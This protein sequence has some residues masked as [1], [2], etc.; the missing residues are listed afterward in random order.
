MPRRAVTRWLLGVLL[1]P[2]LTGCGT[3]M[4]LAEKHYTYYPFTRYAN[5]EPKRIYGGVRIDAEQGWD[6]IA[7]GFDPFIGAYQLAVDLPISAVTDTLTLP[8]TIP[9]TIDR[10]NSEA[11]VPPE[12]RRSP[13]ND[14]GP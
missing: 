11:K 2:A 3:M 6:H 7:D 13:P 1:T 5:S 14:G 8:I 12:L 4:N 9:A 10:M